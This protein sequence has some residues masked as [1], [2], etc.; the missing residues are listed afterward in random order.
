MNYNETGAPCDKKG[1]TL[2]PNTPP[3]PQDI[4]DDTD[5]SP[6]ESRLQFRMAD[7]LYCRDEMS[8]NNI[9]ELMDIWL[10]GKAGSE[11][12]GPFDT[13]EQ[14][15]ATIDHIK[16]GNAPW[17]SFTMSYAGELPEQPE[18][19]QLREY[20]VWFRDPK[21]VLENMLKNPDFEGEINYLPYVELNA[22]DEHCW[23]EFMSGNFAW[24]HASTIYAENPDAEGAAYCPIILGADKTTVSV[25]TG[26]VEYHPL[27]LSIGNINNTVRRA[28]RH[29]P[30]PL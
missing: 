23:N 17:Q 30:A 10:D 12:C 7:F 28:H 6:F 29:I 9:D 16:H 19:W 11:D 2:P 8:A 18:S 25:A 26:H 22:S 3:P 27:Y 20:Q 14:M 15:Y 5:W 24:R 21:V 13:H 1:R 4:L